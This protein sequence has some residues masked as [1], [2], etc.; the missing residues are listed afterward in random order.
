MPGLSGNLT[1]ALQT[2]TQVS[3]DADFSLSDHKAYFR[4]DGEL[5][6]SKNLDLAVNA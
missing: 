2:L 6:R 3:A 1:G 4:A 5:F